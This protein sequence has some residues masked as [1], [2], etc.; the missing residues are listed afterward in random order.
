MR[1]FC[2]AAGFGVAALTLSAL[3]AGCGSATTTESTPSVVETSTPTPTAAPT[4][5]AP[6]AGMHNTLQDYLAA[7]EITETAV[8]RGDPGAPTVDLPR[9]EGWTAPN[10]LPADAY[11]A[12]NYDTPAATENPPRILATLTKLTGDVDPQRVLALAPNA[13]RNLPGY[14]GPSEP[15]REK[16]DNHDSVVIGG[17]YDKDGTT[18]LVAQKTVLIP[19]DG[20]LYVLQ[21]KASG[22]EADAAPLIDA[23]SAIDEDT[24]ITP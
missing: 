1:N 5:A 19:T 4:S 11:G 9:L 16:L 7:N 15:N 2:T 20:G 14:Q 18:V 21:I 23:T 13:V 10:P 12:I 24:K 8:K 3:L 17:M 6:V 22:E